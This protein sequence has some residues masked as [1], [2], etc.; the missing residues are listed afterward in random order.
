MLAKVTDLLEELTAKITDA[1]G[2]TAAIRSVISPVIDEI[3][4]LVAPLES[5]LDAVKS[6]ANVFSAVTSIF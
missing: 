6:V 1:N 4:D 5:L 3:D 2:E